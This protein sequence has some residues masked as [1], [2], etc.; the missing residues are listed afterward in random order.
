MGVDRFVEELQNRTPLQT[1]RLHN[2][3]NALHEAAAGRALA[4][5]RTATPQHR[6]TLDT[7]DVVVG[8]FDTFYGHERPQ[9]RVDPQ[10]TVAKPLGL[11]VPAAQP[12]LQNVQKFQDQRRYP[13][14]QLAAI[15]TTAAK[16]VPQLEN[17]LL[18]AEATGGNDLRLAAAL[19]HC[20]PVPLE[21][22][23]AHLASQHF[24]MVV[25]TPTVAAQ[26]PAKRRCNKP[27]LHSQLQ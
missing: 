6:A 7:L 9:R 22:C 4:A 11:A 21:V 13:I 15:A 2:G 27:L 3:Q 18:H 17:A 24:H 16:Q 1:Q 23:P 26:N 10:Q 12:R 8:R 14:I 19:P 5:K 20:L 25:D